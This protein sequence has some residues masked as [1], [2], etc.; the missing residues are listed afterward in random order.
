MGWQHI[1][2]IPIKYNTELSHAL[3]MRLTHIKFVREVSLSRCEREVY[4]WCRNHRNVLLLM[5]V[6]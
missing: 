2:E 6:K 5:V 4:T 3:T 1:S